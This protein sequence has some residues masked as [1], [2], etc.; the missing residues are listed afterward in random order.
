MDLTNYIYLI[1]SVFIIG[2]GVFSF[3]INGLFL[4][5][6]GNLG[7]R[8][9]KETVIRW[10]VQSKPSI[11]GI[12]FFI[13]F[14]LSIV[15]HFIFFETEKEFLNLQFLGV[16]SA[17]TLAFL[18]GLADD[19]YNTNPFWKFTGQLTCGLILVFTG[20]I[21]HVFQSD[22][23]NI[24]LT[25]FWIIAIMN[26]INM[27]DNMDGITTIVSI[28]IVLAALVIVAILQAF[29]SIYFTV[30]LGLFS[31]LVGFLFY[32]WNP[33]KMFMGDTGSQFLGCILAIFGI[34]F[35]WNFN[36]LTNQTS[37]S[38]QIIIVSLAFLIPIIDTTTVVINRLLKKRSPFIGG[39]DHTTHHISYLG[40]SD[41]KVAR[42]FIALSL[43]SLIF[44]FVIVNFIEAWD[45]IHFTLFSIYI[46]L[47]FSVLYIITRITK[48]EEI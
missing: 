15:T 35:F 44:V 27:L 11:G 29:S 20:T 18:I 6:A 33:S 42:I 47:I 46:F 39:K 36:G 37:E 28:F 9:D 25:V 7:I 2:T 22:F 41:K 14:L 16:L 12:S 40:F 23:F 32:N 45:Y 17:V 19:A 10:S 31:A 3:L 5:F 48:K 4:K 8:N 26:S 43:I 24:L 38:R 1:Y 13:V 21:I 34:I 30:L